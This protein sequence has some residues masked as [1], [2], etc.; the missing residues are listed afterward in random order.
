M[1]KNW[2]TRS[3]TGIVYIAVIVAGILLGGSYFLDMAL[4]LAIPAVMEFKRI[5]LKDWHGSSLNT[6]LD[7]I[8]TGLI[9][10]STVIYDL[11]GIL[12]ALALLTVIVRMISMLY[13]HS[14]DPLRSITSSL[15]V[16]VYIAIPIAMM[17]MI[18]WVSPHLLLLMFVLIWLNDTGAFIVGSLLGRHRLF[19]RI[20]P[21]KSWEGFFGGMVFAIGAAIAAGEFFPEY[22]ELTLLQAALLGAIVTVAATYGDLIESCLKRNAGVKDSG[23]LL[24]G[25]GGMLDRIDSLLLVSPCVVLFIFLFLL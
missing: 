18:R 17:G 22:F 4:I 10:S 14:E 1:N 19:E 11:S 12:L 25:H 5:T 13:N 2:I 3:L 8:A 15:S 6:I 24:P 21:K 7:I 16:L 9:I 20:S 23:N